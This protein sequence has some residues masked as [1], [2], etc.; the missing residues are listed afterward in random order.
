MHTCYDKMECVYI[1]WYNYTIMSQTVHIIQ[2]PPYWLKTPPLSL[3]Y[4]K[5][6]LE[7]KGI[8][9][10]IHDLNH[11]IYKALDLPLNNWPIL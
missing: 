8:T 2:T 4:L 1:A 6:Y 11:S 10:Q 7:R 3:V 5:N 9:A